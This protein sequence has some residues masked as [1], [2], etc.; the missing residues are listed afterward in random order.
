MATGSLPAAR[1]ARW[2]SGTPR[3][4]WRSR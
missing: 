3:R 2:P 1:T 4:C